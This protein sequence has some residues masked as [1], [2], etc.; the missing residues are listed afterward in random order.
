M[1]KEKGCEKKIY[2]FIYYHFL[3]NRIQ[4]P[5]SNLRFLNSHCPQ[6]LMYRS[7]KRFILNHVWVS[8][9]FLSNCLAINVDGFY[10]KAY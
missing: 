9:E 5:S 10:V 2:S 7:L 3:D 4:A 1:G 8:H 6:G